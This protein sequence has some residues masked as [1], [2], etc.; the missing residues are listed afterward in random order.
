MHIK[1][2]NPK[3]DRHLRGLGESLYWAHGAQEKG[4][5][6]CSEDALGAGSEREF[7]GGRRRNKGSDVRRSG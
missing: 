3:K 7:R 1:S 2:R 4:G 5:A 6:R